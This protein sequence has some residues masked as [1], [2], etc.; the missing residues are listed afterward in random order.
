MPA[1]GAGHTQFIVVSYLPFSHLLVVFRLMPADSELLLLLLVVVFP[2]DDVPA[3]IL[4]EVVAISLELLLIFTE[5]SFEDVFGDADVVYIA[6][7]VPATDT[8][9]PV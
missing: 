2:V 7:V 5:I 8:E 6:V 1:D 3:F 9:A 4:D